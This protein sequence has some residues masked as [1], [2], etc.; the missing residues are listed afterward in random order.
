M[1]FR[2]IY[3]NININSKIINININ[4]IIN[5]M[6][7]CGEWL[8]LILIIGLYDQYTISAR[9]TKSYFIQIVI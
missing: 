4:I 7:L 9:Q 8:I 6:R 1:K 3:I 5:A 2:Y